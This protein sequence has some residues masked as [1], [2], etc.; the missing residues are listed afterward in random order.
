M[1][2][3]MILA[4]LLLSAGAA[5]PAAAPPQRTP[6]ADSFDAMLAQLEAAQVEL[7]RGRPEPFKALWSHRDDVTLIGGLGGDIEKGWAGVSRR[8]DWVATQFPEGTRKNDEVARTI[9]GDFA[10]VIVRET[11]HFRAP[12]DR[13][14]VTQE[15]RVTM[16]FRRESGN[17]RL[18]H[19]HAD[20][21]IKKAG[22][23]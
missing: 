18:V 5:S 12:P 7:V 21:Q 4:V 3:R 10:Y 17:W 14:E 1:N 9:S 11:I 22:S 19:R 8:L 2:R 15:L 20:S 6:R 13:R 16:V 23:D